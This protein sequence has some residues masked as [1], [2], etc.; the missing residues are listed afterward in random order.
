MTP[1]FH[2]QASELR[3]SFDQSFAERPNADSRNH[4]I[5]LGIRV[6]TQSFAL[7]LSEISR[8]ITDRKITP[9]PGVSSDL[10]GVLGFRGQMIAVY[11]LRVLLGYPRS[12]QPRWFAVAA[13]AHPVAFAFDMLESYCQVTPDNI[14][15]S[16]AS[17]SVE[18]QARFCGVLHINGSSRTIL[19]IPSLIHDLRNNVRASD[20]SI[21]V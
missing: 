16:E 14:A 13:G 19:S 21:G 2:D 3:A 17:S 18:T 1:N 10:L 6:H 8:V 4:I 15:L 9:I 7:R 11:D 20:P 12:D 5:F